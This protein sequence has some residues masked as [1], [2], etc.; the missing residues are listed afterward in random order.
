VKNPVGEVLVRPVLKNSTR[1]ESMRDWEGISSEKLE[2]E[3]EGLY[4]KKNIRLSEGF[5]SKILGRLM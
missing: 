4:G 1:P 3:Q 5:W 2:K